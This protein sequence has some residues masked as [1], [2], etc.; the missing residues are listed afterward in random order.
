MG[1]IKG[2]SEL[3]EYNKLVDNNAPL[4][5]RGIAIQNFFLARGIKVTYLDGYETPL[6]IKYSFSVQSVCSS[7]RLKSTSELL[8]GEYMSNPH[9]GFFIIQRLQLKQ[10]LVPYEKIE[11]ETQNELVKYPENS[12]K[13]CFCFGQCLEEKGMLFSDMEQCRNMFIFGRSGKTTLLYSLIL[14][15]YRFSTADIYLIDTQQNSLSD[16]R[17][18]NPKRITYIRG[19]EDAQRT[20]QEIAKKCENEFCKHGHF[21][22]NQ[23]DKRTV[24][25]IDDLDWY[26]ID[27]Y[28]QE[29]IPQIVQIIKNIADIGYKVGVHIVIAANHSNIKENS[30]QLLN[31]SFGTK[32]SFLIDKKYSNMLLGNDYSSIPR[33]SGDMLIRLYGNVSPIRVQCPHITDKEILNCITDKNDK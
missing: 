5:T 15:T 1:K 20:L 8:V 6:L 2:Y 31:L 9:G 29:E 10:L 28:R 26:F 17:N 33:H 24:I 16:F 32:V 23:I 13:I 14:Q 7:E 12:N 3:C 30:L 25:F 11:N 22:N 27:K 19:F 4:H 18:L 21:K